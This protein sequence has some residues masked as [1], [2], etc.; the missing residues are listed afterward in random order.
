MQIKIGF[1]FEMP[2][3]CDFSTTKPHSLIKKF[4][5]IFMIKLI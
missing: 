2:L 4:Y 5:V 3:F 1:S